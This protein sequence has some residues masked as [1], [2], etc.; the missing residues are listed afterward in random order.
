VFYFCGSFVPAW[1]RVECD[2]VRCGCLS[3]SF[4]I[5]RKERERKKKKK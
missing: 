5:Q 4:Y 2:C 3:Q 1:V